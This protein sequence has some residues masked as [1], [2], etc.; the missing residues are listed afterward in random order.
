MKTVLISLAALLA[1]QGAPADLSLARTPAETILADPRAEDGAWLF[2]IALEAF[3][4]AD[5]FS[6]DIAASVI[7]LLE[8]AA[9]DGHAESMNLLG[10]IYQTGWGV[11][12]DRE[13]AREYFQ[14]AYEAGNAPAGLNLARGDLLS[15]DP[16]MVR[17]GYASLLVIAENEVFDERSRQVAQGWQGYAISL[18]LGVP[19]PDYEAAYP[20]LMIGL[21]A[22][23]DEPDFNFLA[24]R[25]AESGII[26]EV[27][28]AAATQY[29]TR[30]GEN[31][32]PIAAWRA[33]INY[34]EGVG[35]EADEARAF[36]LVTLSSELGF[37]Q[38]MISLAVMHALGQGTEMRADIART[39]YGAVAMRGNAHAMRSLGMMLLMGEGG[40]GDPA[41]GYAL[42]ELAS[43]AG[44]IHAAD[45]LAA[46][47]EMNPQEE[48]WFA[49]IPARKTEFLESNNLTVEQIYGAQL[50]E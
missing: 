1:A 40:G 7:A 33:G 17:M 30:A 38:G 29:F 45:L 13:R 5:P 9:G 16:R 20:L 3:Q 10:T 46:V 31:G 36:E 6:N 47:N 27:D 28:L 42:L 26:G 48:E 34:L 44:D 25:Y 14:Q 19:E 22:A 41:L 8:R 21:E 2:D 32:H 11:T 49:E 4:A 24:G 39:L 35:V 43:E 23:P 50:A 37:E 15:D 12:A 18:G